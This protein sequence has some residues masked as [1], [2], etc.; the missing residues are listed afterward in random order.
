MSVRKRKTKWSSLTLLEYQILKGK[1]CGDIET[2]LNRLKAEGMATGDILGVM[3][4][5]KANYCYWGNKAFD[6]KQKGRG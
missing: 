5:V 1:A 2:V 6:A 4:T 3:E